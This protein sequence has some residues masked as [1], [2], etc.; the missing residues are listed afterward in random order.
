MQ[1]EI[2]IKRRYGPREQG[3]YVRLPFDVPDNTDALRVEYRYPRHVTESRPEGVSRREANVIDLGLYDERGKLRGWSGS[4]RTTVEIDAVSATPGYAAG[5]VRCGRWAV[6]LGLYHIDTQVEVELI[7]RLPEKR[8]CLLVGDLHMHT[9]NSDGSHTTAQIVEL[10]R[11]EKLDF[12]ALTDHNS[13]QQN[14]EIGGVSGITVIPGTEYTNYRGHANF[15]FTREQGRLDHDPLSNSVEEMRGVFRAARDAGAVISLNHPHSET[16]GWVFGFEELVFHLVEAWTG[17]AGPG[18]VRTIAWWHELLCGGKRIPVVGGSDFHRHELLRSLGSP[19][20]FV[21]S[22]SRSAQDILAAL[23]AGRSFLA[24]SPAGPFVDLCVGDRGMGQRVEIQGT[25][26]G[27]VTARAARAGD[28]VRLLDG[29]GRVVEWSVPF[30]GE[31]RAGF[32]AAA[33][34]LF[35]RLEVW[36]SL[37]GVDLLVALTNPVYIG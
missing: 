3:S 27:T 9:V 33:D 22:A 31:Y 23:V 30:D 2:H 10:A 11:R 25:R 8:E 20:T 18:D 6:V 13:M 29:K 7:I 26:E 36:R 24:F 37:R 28:R 15:Y 12:I 21:H 34:A 35:Y 4:E 32:V 1:R 17:V 5:P 16:C 14:E 19:A